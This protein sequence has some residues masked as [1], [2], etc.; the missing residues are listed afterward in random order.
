LAVLVLVLV[1]V[2]VPESVPVPEP[3]PVPESI[4]VPESVPVPEPVPVPES[5]P[6]P[7][8]VPVPEPAPVLDLD[9]SIRLLRQSQY[10]LRLKKRYSLSDRDRSR[11]L[12]RQH[13]LIQFRI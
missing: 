13:H 4:P 3:V 5:I 9:A 6:V 12:L 7:E 8:P 1:P 10:Y 2:S 11:L